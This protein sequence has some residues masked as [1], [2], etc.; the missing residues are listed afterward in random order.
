MMWNIQIMGLACGSRI[1]LYDGSPFYPD[2]TTYLKFANDQGCGNILP[3]LIFLFNFYS[4]T[5]FGTSPRFL[6]EVQGQGIKPRNYSCPEPWQTT[7]GCK[8]SGGRRKFWRPSHTYGHRCCFDATHV[9]MD[10]E[11]VWRTCTSNILEWGNRC[12]HI[13]WVPSQICSFSTKLTQYWGK[14]WQAHLLYRSMREVCRYWYCNCQN[15]LIFR[16][17]NPSEI[18][19]DESRN[20]RPCWKQRWTHRSTWR[21]GMHSTSP[22]TAS[23]LLGWPCWGEV[24]WRV[25]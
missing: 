13:L 18:A 23:V 17:R 2:I 24:P 20:I 5:V 4:V 10:P 25:L 21:V 14:L 12:V 19:W 7:N 9:W 1:I 16:P 6:A 8:I 11:S 15:Y 3:D 22:F